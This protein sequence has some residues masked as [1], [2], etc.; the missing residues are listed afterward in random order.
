MTSPIPAILL[1]LATS[2]ALASGIFFESLY[3]NES[4]DSRRTTE[5]KARITI[6]DVVINADIADDAEERRRGLSGRA[7]LSD[8]DGMLFLFEQPDRHPI[9][10]KDMLIPID[11]FWIRDGVIIDIKKRAPPPDDLSSPFLP[12]YMPE[13]TA[14]F[15][16][17]VASGFAD[18]HGIR[19]GDGVTITRGGEM[20][21]RPPSQNTVEK[22]KPA[23]FEYFIETLRKT[24][25]RGSDFRVEEVIADTVW[26]TS[27]LVSYL[28]G[29][30]RVSGVMNV[31]KGDPPPEGFPVLILNH[32]L[33]HKSM[34][35]P[36]R[37][38]RREKDFFSRNGYVTLHPDYRGLGESDPDPSEHHDFYVG[39]TRDVIASIDAL[40]AY[41]VRNPFVDMKRIGM[42]GHSMGGGI[43]TRVMVLRP[44]IRAYVLFA[45]ISADVE[46][47]FYEL[48]PA[49]IEWLHETYGA[50]GA[51]GYR[52]MSPIE[53]FNDVT[54]PVQLHYGAA[55]YDVPIEFSEKIFR[56]LTDLGK[57]AEFFI[58]PGQ[59]HE[60]I[61]DWQ[62]AADRSLQFFDYYVK[63]A[64]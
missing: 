6:D 36:G 47:N 59:K 24:Q 14:D 8:F 19:I 28:S 55:D 25:P 46:D 2:G 61:E 60:F 26:Y 45:P 16:L 34:Y 5:I 30:I 42:W 62:L 32:G 56:T 4:A 11:I 33:I 52:T 27:Y 18:R 53:F 49:E 50:E 35:Y 43:A 44:E 15:V 1:I 37:G 48:T 51:E 54:A 63:G 40:A 10:M 64:R 41:N 9:W 38:S 12:I 31:P 17:E 3:G 39:Y 23:G 57:T 20:I 22:Q 21:T 7:A 58:Y 13:N 29:D